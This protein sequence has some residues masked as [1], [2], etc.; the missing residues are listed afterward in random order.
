MFFLFLLARIQDLTHLYF[1]NLLV[2]RK[3]KK[4][5]VA[6]CFENR[7]SDGGARTALSLKEIKSKYT[8]VSKNLKEFGREFGGK[9]LEL[10]LIVVAWRGLESFSAN[11]LPMNTLVLSRT[12]L[13]SLYGPSMMLFQQFYE[14][15]E[16]L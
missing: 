16:V 2:E 4:G 1:K 14:N 5:M 7:W 6:L 3:K 8:I 11:D 12:A 10:Y 9:C 13:Q 15:V